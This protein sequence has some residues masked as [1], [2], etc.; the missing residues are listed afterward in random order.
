MDSSFAVAPLRNRLLAPAAASLQCYPKSRER[1]F[2]EPA[3]NHEPSPVL[4]S[5][6]NLVSLQKWV[7]LK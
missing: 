2:C 6:L 4:S 7:I 1:T 3:H 5:L